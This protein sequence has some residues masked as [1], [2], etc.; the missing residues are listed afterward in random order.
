M[1]LHLIND[2]KYLIIVLIFFTPLKLSHAASLYDVTTALFFENPEE[3]VYKKEL[4]VILNNYSFHQ[5]VSD[6]K[7]IITETKSVQIEHQ[8][9][10]EP[11]HKI[12]ADKYNSEQ[13]SHDSEAQNYP[14]INPYLLLGKDMVNFSSLAEKFSELKK[15][16]PSKIDQQELQQQQIKNHL[17][18]DDYFRWEKDHFSFASL[19]N[20]Y[21]DYIIGASVIIGLL[22]ALKGLISIFGR[23]TY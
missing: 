4:V 21:A 12:A 1:K 15:Y 13:S 20:R 7:T 6:D 23:K 16:K 14:T 9:H 19:W 17:T 11:R 3:S 10:F 18:D 2:Y 8:T 22:S 5:N